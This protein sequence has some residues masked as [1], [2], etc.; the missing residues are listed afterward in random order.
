MADYFAR[1][2]YAHTPQLLPQHKP[3]F[4][5]HIRWLG[6]FAVLKSFYGDPIQM[7]FLQQS[8]P[9]PLHPHFSAVKS[10][11]IHPFPTVAC[12][13]FPFPHSPSAELKGGDDEDDGSKTRPKMSECA[14]FT[15]PEGPGLFLEKTVCS[16]FCGPGGPKP[17]KTIQQGAADGFK[18]AEKGQNMLLVQS[19]SV[20]SHVWTTTWAKMAK[21]RQL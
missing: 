16:I 4:P 13:Q 15:I 11:N 3:I 6:L 8:C 19:Q 7:H 21:P 14:P 5:T 9:D 18:Q 17:G 12:A 20:Q 2:W 1:T 10:A